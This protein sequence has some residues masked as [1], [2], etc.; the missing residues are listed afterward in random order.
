MLDFFSLGFEYSFWITSSFTISSFS[1]GI[2]YLFIL[3]SNS[4][5]KLYFILFS[6]M[7]VK[8]F[9]SFHTFISLFLYIHTVYSSIYIEMKEK[10]LNIQ[11]DM[12]A[13]CCSYVEISFFFKKKLFLILFLVIHCYVVFIMLCTCN[14]YLLWIIMYWTMW[15]ISYFINI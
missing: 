6:F 13:L 11:F 3:F 14:Y 10:W 4:H 2:Y 7:Y 9:F 12:S 1:E 8:F 15:F 5:Q